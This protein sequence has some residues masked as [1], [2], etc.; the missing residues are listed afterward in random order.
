MTGPV[1]AVLGAI[2]VDLVVQGS[3]LPTSGET[4]VGG[5]YSQHQGGKGGNQAVAAARAVG[6]TTQVAMIG[7]VGNDPFGETARD[8]LALEGVDVT[9]V[10]VDRGNATGVALIA[11][12]ANGQNQIS[13]APGANAGLAPDHVESAL[14]SLGARLGGVVASLEVPLDT[15]RA[16]GR[17]CRARSLL[18]VVNPAPARPEVH[19]LLPLATHITPNAAEILI[20]AAQAE[21]PRGAVARLTAAYPELTVISTIGADGAVAGGPE[22]PMRVAGLKV[23]AVDSTGAGDCFNGVLAAGLLESLPLADALRR[24]CVAASLSVTVAGARDGMPTRDQI[25]AASRR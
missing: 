18:F 16:A 8:V 10:A 5:A 3:R 23:R 21:E 25:D 19:D 14:S 12:D 6:A 17:W 24:A 20:V 9:H 7:A 15:V 1:L 2:N 4:V 11:V 22:G 13:V